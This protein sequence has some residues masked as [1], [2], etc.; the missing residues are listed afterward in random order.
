MTDIVADD[1]EKKISDLAKT[2]PK[3][4]WGRLRFIGSLR[5]LIVSY[6]AGLAVALPDLIG[7]DLKQYIKNPQ[8]L[9]PMIVFVAGVALAYLFYEF[10]CPTIVKRYE[11]LPD[12]YEHQ[13][14]IKKLQ[15]ETYPSD[16]FKADLMHVAEHYI[17]ALGKYRVARY[18]TITLYI[19]SFLA[20][21]FLLVRL[22]RAL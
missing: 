1:I 21:L 13:L 10:F 2:I 18:I 6:I 4:H 14:N 16:P 22:Y 5:T 12:F 9:L 20:L 17:K 19:I 11:N 7:T 8:I 15:I 3:L